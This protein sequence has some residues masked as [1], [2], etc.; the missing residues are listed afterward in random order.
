MATPRPPAGL[1][2]MIRRPRMGGRSKAR[3]VVTKSRNRWMRM[4][5]VRA[6]AASTTRS[7]PPREAVWLIAARPPPSVVFAL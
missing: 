1:M 6:K 5:P 2:S 3:A 7:S 4:M